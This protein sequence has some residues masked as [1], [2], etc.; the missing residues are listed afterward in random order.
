MTGAPSSTTNGRTMPVDGRGGQIRWLVCG[1][2]GPSFRY[3][4]QGRLLRDGDDGTI[5]YFMWTDAAGHTPLE[6][7]GGPVP[8]RPLRRDAELGPDW[9]YIGLEVAAANSA[10]Q[11]MRYVTKPIRDGIFVIGAYDD[12]LFATWNVTKDESWGS[13]SAFESLGGNLEMDWFDAW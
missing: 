6:N 9:E 4:R 10:P 8:E 2:P 3:Q 5:Y 7:L 12:L 11:L 1:Q 13:L